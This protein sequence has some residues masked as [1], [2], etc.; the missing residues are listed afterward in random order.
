MEEAHARATQLLTQYREELNKVSEA[1]L[2]YETLSGDELKKIIAGEPLNRDSVSVKKPAKIRS[3][4]P[5]KMEE[6][7]ETSAD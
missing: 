5:K 6:K 2:E 1:L 7:T 3:S 4:I